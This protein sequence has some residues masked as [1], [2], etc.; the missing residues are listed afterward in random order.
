NP[1]RTHLHSKPTN[2]PPSLPS[3]AVTTPLKPARVVL[4]AYPSVPVDW[5]T[6]TGAKSGGRRSR[7]VLYS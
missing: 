2:S 4:G 6:N 1:S 7:A 3:P 5:S